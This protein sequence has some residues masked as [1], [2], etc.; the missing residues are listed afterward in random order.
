[1]SSLCPWLPPS[2]PAELRAGRI[3]L[4]SDNVHTL[5][6]LSHIIPCPRWSPLI[7]KLLPFLQCSSRAPTDEF[8]TC[9]NS[10]KGPE[11]KA[12]RRST[13]AS[14]LFRCRIQLDLFGVCWLRCRR[15]CNLAIY[16]RRLLL[17]GT[18]NRCRRE[19]FSTLVVQRGY[20]F[21]APAAVAR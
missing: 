1:M 9:K 20:G 17:H 5:V 6:S 7:A 12:T 14:R 2:S 16:L 13:S 4:I 3:G 21:V 18:L 19:R 10:K 8:K 11:R 15:V